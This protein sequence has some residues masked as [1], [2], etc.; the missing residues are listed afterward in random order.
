[1]K[2]LLNGIFSKSMFMI[3]TVVLLNS[4]SKD[5]EVPANVINDETGIKIDLDWSTGG[6]VNDATSQTD[7]DLYVYKNGTEIHSS[8]AVSS[9]ERVE[10]DPDFDG[11]GTYMVAVLLYSTSANVSY[12]ATVNG[13]T[14]T[15][16]YK[17]TSTFA[18][19]EESR[20]VTVLK[21]T[22]AGAKY[23]VEEVN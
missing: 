2:T 5:E 17:F 23:T 3:A 10:L 1:M 13:I 12:N 19:T 16:P 22:K 7:L 6:S 9:F 11:D 15:K 8:E 4:C 14:A 18:S 21:I 20:E